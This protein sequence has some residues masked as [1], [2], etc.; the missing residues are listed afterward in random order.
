MRTL[1]HQVFDIL[2]AKNVIFSGN[3]TIGKNR[4]L[5]PLPGNRLYRNS[6][7]LQAALIKNL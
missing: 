3:F 6:I 4:F 2:F 5:H 1:Y 7:R